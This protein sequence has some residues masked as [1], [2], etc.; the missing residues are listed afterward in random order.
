MSALTALM[1]ALALDALEI[2]GI[3]T[4]ELN[5]AI[6]AQAKDRRIS[7]ARQSDALDASAL[8]L[9]GDAALALGASVQFPTHTTAVIAR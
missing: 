9:L 8:V 5:R 7:L 3:D 2:S 4:D 6:T 1:E